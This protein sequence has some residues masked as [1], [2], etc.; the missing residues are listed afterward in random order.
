MP[1]DAKIPRI[2][3]DLLDG[4]EN[5]LALQLQIACAETCTNCEKICTY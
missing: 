1:L 5:I 3:Y 4:P 2:V